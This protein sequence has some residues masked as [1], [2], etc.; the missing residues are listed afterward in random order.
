MPQGLLISGLLGLILYFRNDFRTFLVYGCSKSDRDNINERELKAFKADANDQFTLT[1]E[2]IEAR[3]LDGP[4]LRFIRRL[5]M[6][7]R[8]DILEVIHENASA[9]FKIGAISEERM[10][11]YDELCLV[12]EANAAVESETALKNE[13]SGEMKRIN[14]VTA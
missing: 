11:E 9:N 7:Y 8:S 2:Q 1:N 12:S 3:L 4:L 6:K 14:I 10:R 13:G 5:V